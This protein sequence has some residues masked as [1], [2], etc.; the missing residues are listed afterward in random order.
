MKFFDNTN[1]KFIQN[2]KW[3]YLISSIVIIAGLVSL[4]TKGGPSFSI[5]FTGGVSLELNLAP[6]NQGTPPIHIDQIRKVLKETGVLDAEIQK[7]GDPDAAY[8]LIK[9]KK[10][11]PKEMQIVEILKKAFPEYTN[12]PEQQLIRLQEEVGPKVGA[13]LKVQAIKAVLISFLL[14]IIYIWF[15]F[16]LTF[17]I[18]AVL[19]LIHDILIT[20]GIFSL[21]DKEISVTIIAALLTIV[22]F[23]IN[24]TIVIYDRIREDMK[25]YRKDTMDVVFNNAINRT[26]SR[27]VIT[28]GT[29][30]LCIISLLLFGGSVIRDFAWAMLIGVVSGTYSSV[31]V[32]SPLVVDYY[33]LRGLRDKDIKTFKKKK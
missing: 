26:L 12:K 4:V 3:A 30:I 32:A 15:R 11:D 2:R 1:I 14:M 19:A 20:V 24:D 29:V 25:I 18:A 33:R 31:L 8:F 10:R 17:G 16:E 22:G 9:A 21:L 23:S 13:E 7:I 5:D 6:V 27:T 28:S